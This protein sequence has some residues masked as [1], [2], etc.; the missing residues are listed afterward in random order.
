[1]VGYIVTAAVVCGLM[2]LI[3]LPL[4]RKERNRMQA[5]CAIAFFALVLLGQTFI[6]L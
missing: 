5:V 4:P 1:M 2:I 3:T 6:Q